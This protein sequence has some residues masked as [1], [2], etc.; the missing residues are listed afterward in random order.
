MILPVQNSLSKR[1]NFKLS[2]WVRARGL[3]LPKNRSRT[4][5]KC[6]YIYSICNMYMFFWPGNPQ[7]KKRNTEP[8]KKYEIKKEHNKKHLNDRTNSLHLPPPGACSIFRNF[9]VSWVCV[10]CFVFSFR[11][12]LF[13]LRGFVCCKKEKMQKVRLQRATNPLQVY[14]AQKKTPSQAVPFCLV[15]P[16]YD[17]VI[18]LLNVITC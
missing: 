13:F 15:R 4:Q 17:F 5:P 11:V 6:V 14:T 1:L 7:S 8:K 2:F 9:L 10:F 18:C 3:H 16:R 12:F